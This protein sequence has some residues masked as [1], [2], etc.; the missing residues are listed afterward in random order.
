M[1]ANVENMF[2]CVQGAILRAGF[3]KDAKNHPVYGVLD[4]SHLQS[5]IKRGKAWIAKARQCLQTMQAARPV[6]SSSL[7]NLLEEAKSIQ[8]NL[9]P[10]VR[11]LF[12][13][14]RNTF[15]PLGDSNTQKKQGKHLLLNSFF[16]FQCCFDQVWVLATCCEDPV[17]WAGL[18]RT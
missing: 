13:N 7:T 8:L 2:L 4:D 11:S 14:H 16:F 17:I 5:V 15:D 10:E 6:A 3:P 9:A 12:T 18:G 1:R